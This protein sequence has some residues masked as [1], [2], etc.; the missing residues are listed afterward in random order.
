MRLVRRQPGKA[1]RAE[2]TACLAS[3]ALAVGK[4]PTTS[5]RFEGLVLANWSR[6]VSHSP[7]ISSRPTAGAVVERDILAHPVGILFLYRD[8]TKRVQCGNGLGRAAI[9]ERILSIW[10]SGHCQ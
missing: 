9:S 7:L 3:S 6:G 2:S 10:R 4:R 1:A 8:S 5:L